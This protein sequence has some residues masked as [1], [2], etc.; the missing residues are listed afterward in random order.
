MWNSYG[1]VKIQN[2]CDILAYI[3]SGRSDMKV[4]SNCT[5]CVQVE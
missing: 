2:F 5:E 1:I 3:N 4:N